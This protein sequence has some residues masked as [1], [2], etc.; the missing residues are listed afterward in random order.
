MIKLIAF[1]D[2]IP[3]LDLICK[4]NKEKFPKSKYGNIVK[5]NFVMII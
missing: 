3:I 5:T 4:L 1:F 2:R